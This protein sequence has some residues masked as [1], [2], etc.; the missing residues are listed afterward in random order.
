MKKKKKKGIRIVFGSGDL[1]QL[2]ETTFKQL[3]KKSK[4]NSKSNSPKTKNDMSN[5]CLFYLFLNIYYLY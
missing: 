5:I 3:G 2:E 4:S 1:V